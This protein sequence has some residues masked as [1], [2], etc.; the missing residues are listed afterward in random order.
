MY[1]SFTSKYSKND[2]SRAPRYVEVQQERLHTLP[3]KRKIQL[4]DAVEKRPASK[5]KEEIAEEFGIVP[6]T[7]ST[8]LKNT[9]KYRRAFYGGRNQYQ[10]EAAAGRN[11]GRHQQFSPSLFF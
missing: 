2:E 5:K 9:E 11:V 6:N 7:L 1:I 8:I 10:Q 4:I 3:L